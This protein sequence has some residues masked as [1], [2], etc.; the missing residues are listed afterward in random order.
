MTWFRVDDKMMSHPKVLRIPRAARHSTLGLWLTAGVWCA[1]QLTNGRL[2]AYMLPELGATKR[3]AQALVDCGL[4]ELDGDEYVFHDWPDYQPTREHVENERAAARERM[5]KRRR[6][7]SDVPANTDGT[8]TEVRRP[9]PDPT[10]P[11]Q[12][13]TPQGG[14]SV[15]SRGTRLPEGWE[16]PLDAVAAMRAEFP[17]LDLR[18]A[19]ERFT[20]H[21]RSATRSATKRDW[22]AAWRN[23]IREDARRYR[24]RSASPLPG[25]TSVTDE[26]RAWAA[27]QDLLAL[28][29]P[30]ATGA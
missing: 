24:P 2:P 23:W 1:G 5:A 12:E 20:D 25:R 10:K 21:W 30:V 26:D 13:Q 17:Y 15:S 22:L 11:D 6:T 16:P 9:R 4:W 18:A 7:P 3:Q 14:P 19:H 29:P 27:E 8:S 28:T